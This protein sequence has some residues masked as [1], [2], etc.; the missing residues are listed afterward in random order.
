MKLVVV[1]SNFQ[2]FLVPNWR[3]FRI[4]VIYV[5]PESPM[6]IFS[7]VRGVPVWAI[8]IMIIQYSIVQVLD[9][10]LGKFWIEP[11]DV[12]IAPT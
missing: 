5:S 4:T 7:S 8:C 1:K 6:K 12:G 11:Q 10:Y 3:V 9:I 2:V